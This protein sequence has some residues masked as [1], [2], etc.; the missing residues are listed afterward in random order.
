MH[1]CLHGIM[2]DDAVLLPAAATV[3]VQAAEA[4]TDEVCGFDM[5]AI[6]RYRWTP[7]FTSGLS[8]TNPKAKFA[9]MCI[10]LRFRE[11]KMQWS[12]SLLNCCRAILA[13]QEQS[14]AETPVE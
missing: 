8:R 6:N 11:E 7:A 12:I 10:F 1:H 3:Y 4:R 2:A 14:R 9:D 13:A 5:S